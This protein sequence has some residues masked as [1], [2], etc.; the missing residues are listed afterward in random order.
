M[1]PFIETWVK[2]LSLSSSEREDYLEMYGFEPEVSK[3]E[4]TQMDLLLLIPL[5][6]LMAFIGK[7][8]Y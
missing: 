5:F 3:R 7:N 1:W 2:N 8:K 6:A 4:S